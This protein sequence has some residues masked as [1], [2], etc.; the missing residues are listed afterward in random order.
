MRLLAREEQLIKN[1]LNHAAADRHFVELA[2]DFA[3]QV[4]GFSA[5]TPAMPEAGRLAALVKAKWQHVL[6]ICGGAHASVLPELTLRQCPALDA[7]AV[8]EAELTMLELCERGLAADVAGL[9]FRRDGEIVLTPR[10]LPHQRLDELGPPAWDLLDLAHYTRPQP[11]MIRYL[12]LRCINI[13]TSRGCSNAC[14]FCGGHLVGGV[15]VRM[16][17]LDYV[18]DQLRRALGAGAQAVHFEDDT[19]AA[20]RSRLLELC[21]AMRSADLPFRLKWDCCMRVDQADAELLSAMKAAG[22]IQVEF[23]FESGSDRSLAAIGKKATAELNRRAAELCRQAGLRIFADIMVGLPGETAGDL[24]ATKRFLRWARPHAVS[25]ARLC[26]LPGTAVYNSLGDAQKQSLSW[27]GYA[28]LDEPGN[29][30]NFTA[31]GEAA[32]GRWY[33]RFM[34]HMVAPW[35]VRARLRDLPAGDG[36][37][38]R[39]LRRIWRRFAWRHPLAAASIRRLA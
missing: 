14:E 1:G 7:A 17:S 10:R 3:P 22:C 28:Y 35:Q 33:R 36:A 18:I 15:G 26:P 31:L 32:F 29:P 5:T 12:P 21:E 39:R 16:H 9:A 38:R 23:G 34:R 20:D 8:G 4:V 11:W 24:A 27:E 37:E 25:A 6:T 19:L 13:R 30:I 2:A